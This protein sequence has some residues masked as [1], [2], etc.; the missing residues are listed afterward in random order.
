M[1][2]RN[3]V[4]F[5][6]KNEITKV[7]EQHSDGVKLTKNEIESL[8]NKHSNFW[9]LYSGKTEKSCNQTLN[10]YVEKNLKESLNQCLEAANQLRMKYDKTPWYQSIESRS[11]FTQKIVDAVNNAESS[12]DDVDRIC[13]GSGIKSPEMNQQFNLILQSF[14]SK[15]RVRILIATVLLCLGYAYCA[16]VLLAFPTLFNRIKRE[17]LKDVRKNGTTLSLSILSAALAI[18]IFVAIAVPDAI[19]ISI[20]H[21]AI[22]AIFAVAFVAVSYL[23]FKLHSIKEKKRTHS[24]SKI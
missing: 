13:T 11:K 8:E 17:T 24:Y 1:A 15:L 22:I 3:I 21:Y 19:W 4:W 16:R 6:K 7:S 9:N 2:N 10:E 18:E 20:I 12:A 5:E 14:E 23:T